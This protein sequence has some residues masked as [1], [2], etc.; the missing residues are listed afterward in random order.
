MGVAA[1]IDF[2][3][4]LLQKTLF[5]LIKMKASAPSLRKVNPNST[6]YDVLN[7]LKVLLVG[8]FNNSS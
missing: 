5:E 6:N 7:D 2:L 8:S 3:N 1:F 4:F